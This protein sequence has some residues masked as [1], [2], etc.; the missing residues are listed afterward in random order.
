MT[1]SH[2]INTA[3]QTIALA[4]GRVFKY[5]QT[6]P[7]QWNI[8]LRKHPF[9]SDSRFDVQLE[10]GNFGAFRMFNT[11]TDAAAFCENSAYSG[12]AVN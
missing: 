1:H 12:E 9:W 5:T 11:I 3:T 2:T 10:G 8:G 7:Q 6:R 4:D